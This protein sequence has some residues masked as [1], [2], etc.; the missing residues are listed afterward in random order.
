MEIKILNLLD[1]S[2]VLDLVSSKKKF[3]QQPLDGTVLDI[4]VAGIKKSLTN[5]HRLRLI[6]CFD[7]GDLV[8][9]VSQSF[10]QN[11]PFWYM[12]Y[13][14]SRN[15]NLSFA[16]G[17]GDYINSCLEY[18]MRDAESKGFFDVYYSVPIHYQRTQRKT[19][20]SS[21]AWSRYDIFI[22]R[23]IDENTFPEYFVHKAAYGSVLKSHKVIIKKAVLKQEYR[24]IEG[25]K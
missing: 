7:S 19:H 5:Q 18:A 1:E 15:S 9:V 23:I 2:A 11:M 13:F 24:S 25:L 10:D 17:H 20:H 3:S 22:E 16:N 21:P 6:G 8:A 4:L 12:D 14:F